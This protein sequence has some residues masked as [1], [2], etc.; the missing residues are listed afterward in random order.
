[1]S[2]H[3]DP[4]LDDV[5]QDEELQ[6]IASLLRSARLPDPPLDDAFRSALRRQLMQRAWGATEQ[7]E[8]WWQRIF[9]G[10]GLA[11]AGAAVGTVL[12]ASVVV[13][14]STQ[15]PGTLSQIV[16]QSPIDDSSAVKLSQPIL[17]A[18][19]QPM[20]H[21]STEKA[22]QITPATTVAYSWRE[23]TLAVRPTSGALAP[24]TQYQVTIGPGAKTAAGQK[25]DA[26]KTITFVTQP[27]AAVVPP[28]PTPTA[29]PNVLPGGVIRLGPIPGD[30]A[31]NPQWAPDSSTVYFI[32]PGGAVDAAPAKGGPVKV[33]VGDGAS[34]LAL[35]PAGDR[36]AYVRGGKV[37]VLTIAAD[38]TADV[39]PPSTPTTVG[40]VADKLYWGAAD[41]VYNLAADGPAKV[42]PLT[43]SGE[44][45]SVLSISPDGAHA[46][47]T[48][49]GNFYVLDVAAGKDAQLGH[50][51]DAITFQGWSPDSSRLIFNNQIADLQGHPV[52]RLP[53]GDP[54]WSTQSQVL[55]GT[56][57]ELTEIRPDGTG[58][59]KLADG[60][61]HQPA[62]APDSTTF[63]FV[64][65]TDLYT[66]TAPAALPAP[67]ATVAAAAVVNQ[68][69]QARLGGDS[70]VAGTFLDAAGAAAYQSI[71][72]LPD[73]AKGFKRF[74]ILSVAADPASPN[75]IQ[76]VVRLVFGEGK[77][78]KNATEET[79]TV[80]R[81]QSSDPFLIHAAISGTQLNLGNGAEVVGVSL[82]GSTITVTFDSDLIPETVAAGVM[83]VDSK[84]KQTGDTPTYEKR[85]VTI[86]GLDLKQN[87]SY[88]LVVL[89]TVQ[90]VSGRNFPAEYDFNL[91]GTGQGNGGGNGNGNGN[92][93]G[94]DGGGQPSPSPA[95]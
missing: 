35:A 4:E 43:E 31:E 53:A 49:G 14:M 21:P 38:T 55:V 68:F 40:W 45:P 86:T 66:S 18:F 82:N 94:S 52:S 34:L 88:K 58:K 89:T 92:G 3:H 64:R 5:L 63:A 51:G 85:T 27:T 91:P 78:E 36:L 70:N 57:T 84:G 79:L 24:N 32:G 39:T 29:T 87:E 76:I 71:G 46:V 25:L 28:S 22:V 23:N 13:F 93:G 8:P 17:V 77:S 10:T 42:S 19:N 61:Y 62:W 26:P 2:A 44:N 59:T 73:A 54:D 7:R 67:T 74:Y 72:L 20:D 6:R 11:W 12:I 90:D 9:G 95:A 60:T 83:V 81:A 69:M 75:T 15:Q 48:A 47:F 16:I 1:M 41:G 56:D 80:I 30:A 50:S 65:G 37:E 33:L